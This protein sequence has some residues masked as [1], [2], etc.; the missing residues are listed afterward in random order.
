M[1]TAITEVVINKER[2]SP[3][4][5]RI[6][7]LGRLSLGVVELNYKEEQDVEIVPVVGSRKAAGFTS[8]NQK[9][10]GDIT[11]LREEVLGM[12]VAAGGSVLDL[13]PF[14]ITISTFKNGL[15]VK[16]TLK[17]VKIQSVEHGVSG[18]SVDALKDKL[19][20]KAMDLKH[21]K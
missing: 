16:E 4:D 17:F 1:A 2:F 11:L 15:L 8:G 6:T 13:K 3:A 18:G 7:F 21:A 10:S 9:Y 5:V 19:Q 20:F 14:P 12:Q